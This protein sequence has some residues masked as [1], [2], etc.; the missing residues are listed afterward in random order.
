MLI[1]VFLGYSTLQHY[2][3]FILLD[4]QFCDGR[5]YVLNLVFLDVRKVCDASFACDHAC[6]TVPVGPKDESVVF[7]AVEGP[8]IVLGEQIWREQHLDGFEGVM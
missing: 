3:I 1:N 8:R 2:Q 4:D 7:D 5:I 6:E